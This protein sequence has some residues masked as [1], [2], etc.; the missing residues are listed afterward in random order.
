MHSTLE[1]TCRQGKEPTDSWSP[2]LLVAEA[3]PL[4]RTCAKQYDAKNKPPAS[5]S[6][7]LEKPSALVI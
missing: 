1:G 3:L 6:T 2:F 7:S 5:P 4:L